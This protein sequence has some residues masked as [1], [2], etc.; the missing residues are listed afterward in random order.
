MGV[1]LAALRERPPFHPFDRA[2][3]DAAEV[4]NICTDY[5]GAA[6]IGDVDLGAR[7][8]AFAAKVRGRRVMSELAANV[9]AVIAP[10]G[11]TAAACGMVSGAKAERRS[12]VAWRDTP[13]KPSRAFCMATC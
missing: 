4:R 1:G 2:A 12:A 11:M 6:G 8:F 7:A 9:H 13:S 5:G 10:L 3:T